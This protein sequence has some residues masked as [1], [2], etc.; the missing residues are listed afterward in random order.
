MGEGLFESLS[1]VWGRGQGEGAYD[2]KE[3]FAGDGAGMSSV[4][5]GSGRW[6]S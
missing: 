4:V 5:G 2:R 6:T 3:A 1:P